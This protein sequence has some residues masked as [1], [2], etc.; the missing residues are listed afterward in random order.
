[1]K[2]KYILTK[3]KA[4]EI[5]AFDEHNMAH[6]FYNMPFGLLGGD[7]DKESLF[8]DIDNAYAC[9]K[10]GALALRVGH[11]LVI[12]PSKE[13]RQSHLLFVETINSFNEKELKLL[14]KEK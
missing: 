9:K 12:V 5:I 1:M 14:E 8:T 2:D 13:C 6:T 10:T 4:K 11:G 3:E 7:H